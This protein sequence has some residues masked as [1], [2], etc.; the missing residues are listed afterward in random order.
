MTEQL[1]V[2]R[3]YDMLDGWIDLPVA[4]MP[5]ADADALW[6]KETGGGT[7]N[8]RYAD[9]DYYAI[10]PADTQMLHTPEFRGR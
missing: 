3:L 4:P 10:F 6:N 9:G 7:R 1:F 8:T 2:V 5:R